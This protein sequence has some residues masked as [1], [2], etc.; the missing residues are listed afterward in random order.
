[1][2]P[3]AESWTAWELA[4]LGGR[5][6]QEV[7][8]FLAD[9]EIIGLLA[10]GDPGTRQYELRLLA[11]EL[12]NRLVRFRRLVEDASAEAREGLDD[13]SRAAQRAEVRTAESAQGIEH[14]IEVR[15]DQVANEPASARDAEVAARE[16]R[17]AVD[18]LRDAEATLA[19]AR[20][21]VG[22][23]APSPEV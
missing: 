2:R 11:T 12:T 21:E 1:M 16:T 23:H 15:Q 8:P 17:E 13:A 18:D 9:E 7:V 19:K 4:I 14:H 20:R 5:S 22:R 10:T 3:D 6:A